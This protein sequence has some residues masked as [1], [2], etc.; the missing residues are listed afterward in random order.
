MFTAGVLGVINRTPPAP[1]ESSPPRV[2]VNTETPVATAETFLD[3]WRKRDHD[4]ATRLSAGVARQQVQERKRSDESLSDDERDVKTQ[5]WDAMA[6]SR[7]TLTVDERS[8]T[9]DGQTLLRTRAVGEF[10]GRPYERRVAFGL[11]ERDGSWRVTQMIL[12]EHLQEPP[13]FLGSASREPER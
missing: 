1:P 8:E 13:D 4:T 5:V 3:A 9:D 12:G 11:T 6:S 10:L 7:L 2:E